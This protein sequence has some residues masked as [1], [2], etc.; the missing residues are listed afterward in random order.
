MSDTA[1][2]LTFTRRAIVFRGAGRS[3][4]LALAPDAHEGQAE[5]R[6]R[7]RNLSGS[8]L[9]PSTRQGYAHDPGTPSNLPCYHG[10][11]QTKQEIR[12]QV[13]DILQRRGVARFPGAVGRIPNFDGTV[14]AA[15]LAR[16]LQAWQ[17]ARVLKCNP[18][19][20]QL[21]LRRAALQ[22]GKTIYMAVPRL[23]QERCFIE[24]DPNQL[25]HRVSAAATIRGA[26]NYGRPVTVDE[27]RLIDLV[28]CGSVAVNR[29]GA[30]V[31]KGGGYSDLEYAL[32]FVAGKL[33]TDTPILT[34]VHALQL[35]E[36][37][38]PQEVHDIPVDYIVTPQEVVATHTSLP[39]PQ[40]IY[41]ELLP[42]EKTEAIPALRKMAVHLPD[43]A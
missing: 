3:L 22:E 17:R 24:L 28:I 37:A 20:P 18:D 36:E 6:P 42:P 38:I 8:D 31:G 23:R 11:V 5:A 9:L 33:S 13:W 39:R 1:N 34:T 35:I 2:Y 40:G 27:L 30:R 15:E 32:A 19:S 12:D 7:K 25:R 4:I 41:W 21:P 29:K 43:L 16:R 10:V 26:F 14:Q